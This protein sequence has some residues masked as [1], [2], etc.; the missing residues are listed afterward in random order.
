MTNVTINTNDTIGTTQFIFI[1]NNRFN[2]SNNIIFMKT[3]KVIDCN[4]NEHNLIVDFIYNVTSFTNFSREVITNINLNHKDD[5][6]TFYV[7]KTDE[8]ISS[9]LGRLELHK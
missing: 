4:K 3:I 9:F 8:P 1:L 7:I 6:Y 5:N 2:I